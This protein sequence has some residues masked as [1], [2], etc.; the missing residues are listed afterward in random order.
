MTAS[1]ALRINTVLARAI[2][3]R[4]TLT[5]SEWAE[6]APRVMSSK[7][8]PI[9]GRWRNDNNPLLREPMD[10]LSIRSPVQDIVIKFCIQIGKTEIEVNAL[11]YSICENPGP[12]M[13]VLPDEISLN[14]WVQQKLNPMIEGTEV[15]RNALTSTVSRN[16]ANQSAFKDFAGGQL[17]VEHGKTATRMAM[18]S[19]KIMLVDEFDKFAAALTS[20]EDPD[21]LIEGRLSAF[22]Q[23][24]KR[25]DVGSPGIKGV[26]RIDQ[27]WEKS[28]QRKYYV[29]CP[30]CGA[31]QPFEWSGLHWSPGGADVFYACRENGCRIDEHHKRDMIA[32]GHWVAENP[33]A[34]IRGYTTNCLYYDFRMGP[35]WATLVEMWL[36]AQTDPAKLQVFVQERL[37]EAWED[38]AMRNVKHNVIADRAENYL[39]RSAPARVLAITAGVDTQDDRLEVQIV[40]WARN[41]AAWTLDYVVLPGDPENDATWVSLVD[42][43]NRPIE[44]ASGNLL[45]VDALAIDAAGHRTQAVYNFV[46]KRLLRRCIP[47]FGAKPNNAPVLS[48]GKLQDV[49]FRG[50]ADRRG[51]TIHHI[52][53]VAIKHMLYGRISSDGDKHP[54][55]R[56]VHMSDQLPPEYF[57][58]MVSETYDARKN[59]FVKRNGVR[60]EPL[61]TWTLAYAATHHPE[62]RLH[63]LS[64]LEWDAREARLGVV[65]NKARLDSI[66]NIQSDKV[67]IVSRGASA[68]ASSP[69]EPPPPSRFARRT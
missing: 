26:S 61:D 33:G 32:K 47:T 52:G 64:K 54:D 19:V 65:D 37:A 53:T 14:K 22:P 30:H 9:A 63:R 10:C 68:P 28:D 18:T 57:T 56:L 44:H 58:G 42:L 12:I 62:L 45:R 59:R 16:A 24:Y 8:S 48:R 4:K 15:V 5:V 31:E 38:P 25:I 36:D 46:R 51:I 6:T 34:R 35:R 49:N 27:K 1:A 23:T 7:T 50:V 3:P 13:V 41:L 11:G 21:K 29:P 67:Q 55:A 43:L 17:F 40:G 39:L 2:A 20:G 66:A 69:R 60:N